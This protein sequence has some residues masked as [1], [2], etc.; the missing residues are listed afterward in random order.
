MEN[1]VILDDFINHNFKP[2]FMPI[3]TIYKNPSDYPNLYVARL[4]D[5][6]NRT[7]IITKANSLNAIRQKIPKYFGRIIRDNE[8]D[9]YIIESYV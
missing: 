1:D 9:P 8:D 2:Y 3:I 6:G 4:F 7:N 5:F